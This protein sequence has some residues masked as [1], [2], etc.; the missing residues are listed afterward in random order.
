MGSQ[1]NIA[2]RDAARAAGF[3]ALGI[4]PGRPI[5]HRLVADLRQQGFGEGRGPELLFV[6][7]QASRGILPRVADCQKAQ[8]VGHH[9]QLLYRE[10]M[11]LDEGDSMQE[12]PSEAPRG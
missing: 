6:L 1:D 11:S 3:M 12:S 8:E 7:G 5:V 10:A 4:A 2:L 9:H